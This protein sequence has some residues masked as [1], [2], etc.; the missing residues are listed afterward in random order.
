M[1]ATKILLEIDKTLDQLIQNA[2]AIQTADLDTLSEIEIDAFR[3]TQ[4]SLVH[5][6][7]Y[8]DEHFS[9]QRAASHTLQTKRKKFETLKKSYH[10]KL[11]ASE[12]K[13][14]IFSKRRCKKLFHA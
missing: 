9:H 13:K 4:E 3:K 11:A 6:L 14:T 10:K 7:L 8:M 12:L 2:E 1:F 5:H